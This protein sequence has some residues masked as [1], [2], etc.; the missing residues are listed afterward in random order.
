LKTSDAVRFCVPH[1]RRDF[2]SSN[3]PTNS[4]VKALNDGGSLY[5]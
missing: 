2:S 3:D 5:Q 1:R 4:S